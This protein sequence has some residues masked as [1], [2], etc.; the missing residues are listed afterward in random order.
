MQEVA[1]IKFQLASIISKIN[2]QQLF[3]GFILL[4]PLVHYFNTLKLVKS[5]KH[6]YM[7]RHNNVIIRG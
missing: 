4:H 2:L 1:Q 7:F 6:S 3:W 5:L